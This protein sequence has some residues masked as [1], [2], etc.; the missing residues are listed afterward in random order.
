VHALDIVL[1]FEKDPAG[2]SDADL[3][4][5]IPGRMLRGIHAAFGGDAVLSEP[6]VLGTPS[7]HHPSTHDADT[8]TPEVLTPDLQLGAPVRELVA[9]PRE[10]WRQ[11]ARLSDRNFGQAVHALFAEIEDVE[12]W[13]ARRAAWLEGA[14]EEL[15]PDLLPVVEAVE[16]VLRDPQAG[17]TFAAGADE[18]FLER[19]WV[20]PD[21]RIER[22]DRV[23]R[24][25]NAWTVVDFKTGTPDD[26][27][28]QQVRSYLS[29]LAALAPDAE[30]RGALIYTDSV[31]VV[32]VP[33]ETLF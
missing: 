13:A 25:G 5:T 9:M 6:L 8:P 11:E 28:K 29:T 32:D 7:G 10:D 33:F 4:K 14:T 31:K 1:E 3:L 27:H 20:A 19:D 22:P 18:V 17:A 16:A 24:R 23:V 21:G 30:I 26:K 12:A 2:L 15:A